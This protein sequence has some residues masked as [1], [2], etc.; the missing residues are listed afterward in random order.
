MKALVFGGSGVIGRTGAWDLAQDPGVEQVGIVGRR[1]DALEETCRWIGSDKVVPHAVD[2][3]ERDAVVQLMRG[4]DVGV[5]SLPDRRT[6]YLAFEYAL[7]AGLHLVDVLEEYHRRPDVYE[8]EGLELPAGMSLP[9]YGESLH[10]RAR[11]QGLTF[12]DGIGFAPGLSN[13]TLGEGIR[14][15]DDAEVAIAR[16][17]GVPSKE[18]AAE[19]PL[20][21]M[22]T[23]TFE[24]VL[25]EYVIHLNVR[26]DGKV[27]EVPAGGDRERFR[28]RQ[29][30]RDEEL[31]C[32][33]TPGMP[34]FIYTRPQLREFA[35]KTVRWPGHWDAVDT[36][37]ECG[38]LSVEPFAYNGGEVVPRQLLSALLTPRL[39]PREGDTDV[40]VM[41]N[42]LTGTRDG[43]PVKVEYFMWDEADEQRGMSA[44]MRTTAFPMAIAARMVGRR[45]IDQTGIVAPEDA[46]AGGLY[47][48]FLAELAARG[49]AIERVETDL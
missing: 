41:Y 40:C 20:R 31:E 25:R 22:I 23:W 3:A 6:S 13:V 21:Y 24:H 45:Q 8:T 9:E 5:V 2:M 30:E 17:G 46:I 37:K 44:M 16:V 39:L 49:I 4:Y 47:R 34:S 32:A 12:L 19:H 38:L 14:E 28:F 15:I 27:V 11:Q 10:E 33:V 42:T 26:Q 7:E 35:E 48:E 29:L 1:R 36:L 18:A 43:R